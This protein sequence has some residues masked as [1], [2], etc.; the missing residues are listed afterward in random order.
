MGKVILSIIVPVYNVE[1]YVKKLIDSIRNQTYSKNFECILIDDG[2]TDSSRTVIEKSINNLDN[3][4]LI[5]KS[6]NG[7]SSAR[8]LG[9]KH[10]KGEYLYFADPDDFLEKNFLEAIINNINKYKADLYFFGYRTINEKKEELFINSYKEEIFNNSK[11]IQKNFLQLMEG[12]N[13][14]AV[15]NKVYKAS[16][17]SEHAIYF[18]AMRTAEDAVFNYLVYDKAE[19]LKVINEVLYNYLYNRNDSALSSNDDRFNDD[20]VLMENK[21]KIFKT[22]ENTN[23]DELIIRSLSDC[24]I[25]QLITFKGKIPNK[26]KSTGEY[27]RILENLN[28]VS[29]WKIRDKKLIV[30]YFLIRCG[31]YKLLWNIVK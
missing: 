20:Y 3:F 24:L 14:N 30:K 18:P 15:W 6:N 1:N 8:N 7:V 5:S 9:I 22:W 21:I 17:I 31:F 4:F 23:I 13:V 16:L 2:S 27:K 10:A 26:V 19:S 29:I 12:K 11:E 28:K 25:N